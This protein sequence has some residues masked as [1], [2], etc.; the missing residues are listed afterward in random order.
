M[1]G[2]YCDE[3]LALNYGGQDPFESDTLKFIEDFKIMGP[4]IKEALTQLSK[5]TT[6]DKDLVATAI[7]ILEAS[8]H[9]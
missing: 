2:G 7:R 4:K 6:V 5:N 1:K 3:F 9:W 8:A